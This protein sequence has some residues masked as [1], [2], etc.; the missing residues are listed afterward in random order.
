MRS[1]WRRASSIKRTSLNNDKG[2]RNWVDGEETRN[3]TRNWRLG[4]GQR[5]VRS[6]EEIVAIKF[7]TGI[8]SGRV[9][10]IK[11]TSFVTSLATDKQGI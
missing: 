10:S 7:L 4:T 1:L 6:P 5:I 9:S 2:L 11:R 8:G 3:D